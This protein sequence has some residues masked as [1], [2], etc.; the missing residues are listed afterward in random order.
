MDARSRTSLALVAV[1]VAMLGAAFASKP[2]Y[3]AFCRATGYGGTTQRAAK[4]AD[5]V[6]D[7]TMVVRFDA[8]AS[9]DAGVIFK[10]MQ[11][12]ETVRLGESTLAFFTVENLSAEPVD[13]VASFNVTPFKA[14]TYFRK[15]ECFCF[16]Q[17]RLEAG[18]SLGMPVL[19]FVDPLLDEND[20][21]DDV[22]TI[23]LSYTMYRS[24]ED[25]AADA[26][27]SAAN[28]PMPGPAGDGAE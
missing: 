11:S 9:P 2:L 28:R 14:G 6:L 12:E 22:Q 20:Y 8:N 19:Y 24:L 25:A 7:R 5:R 1:A 16:K 17:Q 3:D 21:L 18:E 27:A 10:P 13:V 23:T 15:I 4:G 26:A